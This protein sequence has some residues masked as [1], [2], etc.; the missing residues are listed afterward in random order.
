MFVPMDVSEA[1]LIPNAYYRDA[2]MGAQI[3]TYGAEDG[4]TWT[5]IL[6]FPDGTTGSWAPITF[7]SQYNGQENCFVGGGPTS[8]GYTDYILAWYTFAQCQPTGTYTIEF[9][10]NGV[11]FDE[12]QFNLWPQIKD[13]LVPKLYQVD[14]KDPNL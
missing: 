10:F 13:G 14:Y 8:C 7:Y 12:R 9:L 11:K 5:A 6:K 2:Y 1:S 3:V 4:D